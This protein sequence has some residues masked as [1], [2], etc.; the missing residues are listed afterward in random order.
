MIEAELDPIIERIAREARRPV[1]VDP[2]ARV[3]LVAAIRAE[4][5]PGSSDPENLFTVLPQ[6]GI[7]PRA[8]S[9]S[10]CS[11]EWHSR[12]AGTVR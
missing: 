3:R 2:D 12:V 8:W 7:R 6:R 5:A 10:A 1:A 11:P 9:A 4:G